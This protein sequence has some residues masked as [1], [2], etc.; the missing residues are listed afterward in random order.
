MINKI[1]KNPLLKQKPNH[2]L[3]SYEVSSINSGKN[4]HKKTN[5]IIQ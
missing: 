3:D 1:L 2:Q 5:V 4:F